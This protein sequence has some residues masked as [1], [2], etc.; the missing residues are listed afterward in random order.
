MF[1]RRSFNGRQYFRKVKG[2]TLRNLQ[3]IKMNKV[4]FNKL[5]DNTLC[6]YSIIYENIFIE[7]FVRFKN[8]GYLCVH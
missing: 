8:T 7:H 6:L 2:K 1:F 4:W 3:K 5:I